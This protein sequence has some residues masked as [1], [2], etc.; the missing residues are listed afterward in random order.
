MIPGHEAR[1]P[2]ALCWAAGERLFG[3]GLGGVV[4]EFDLERLRVKSSLD[5]FGG[6]LWSMAAHPSGAQLA[7]RGGPRGGGRREGPRLRL[8]PR[9]EG[10]RGR[11]RERGCPTRPG[12]L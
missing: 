2:E 3:A 5:A 6:P 9:V 12:G 1:A 4:V 11:G 7:V 8:L 10:R